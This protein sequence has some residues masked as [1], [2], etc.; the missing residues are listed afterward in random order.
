MNAEVNESD[1]FI[2]NV[3]I[4]PIILISN[5]TFIFLVLKYKYAYKK[6]GI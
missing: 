6:N 5:L 2:A 4:V 3:K 1:T